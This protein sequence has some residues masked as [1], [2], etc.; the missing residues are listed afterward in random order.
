VIISVVYLLG[1]CLLGC[2]ILLTRHRASNDAELLVL[3]PTCRTPPGRPARP[4]DLQPD[5]PP[6]GRCRRLRQ[7]RDATTRRLADLG[8][9]AG[10]RCLEVGCGA[11]GVALWLGRQVGPTGRVLATDL[12]TRFLARHAQPNL[13]VQTHDITADAL[14]PGSFDLAHTRNVLA[15]RALDRMIGT[16]RPGGWILVEDT[17]IGQAMLSAQARYVHPT[18]YAALLQRIYRAV[19]AAFTAI[20]ADAS[21]GP[22]LA[23]WLYEAGLEHVGAEIHGP[24]TAGGTEYW[25]RG[26][27]E[28]LAD[29]LAATGLVTAADVQ[30]YLTRAAD[31]A[32]FYPTPILVSA[33]GQRPA[34][35][36][37]SSRKCQPLY[38]GEAA[39]PPAPHTAILGQPNRGQPPPRRRWEG[40][41]RT[42]RARSAGEPRSNARR[43]R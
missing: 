37:A 6:H 20:G 22:H 15:R 19:Q 18:E 40:Q 29:R 3:R 17:D 24:V 33:W 26:S 32:F 21:I 14:E 7:P 2:L 10:W 35:L 13:D 11:G 39:P 38:R 36:S 41:Y 43:R 1:R 31:P 8:V 34:G 12:D 16:V 42:C 5:L 4:A 25:A 9:R 28:Q 30:R 23:S 27:I